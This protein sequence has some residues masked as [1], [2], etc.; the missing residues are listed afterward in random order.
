MKKIYKALLILF[1]FIPFLSVS[2][3]EKVRCGLV[4]NIPSKIP[5]LT[6][7]AF[8][9]IQ[10]IVPILLVLMGSIDLFKGITAQKDEDIKKGQRLFIKRLVVAA[11][12]FFV[13]VVVKFFV[14]I[15]AD[16]SS[17]DAIECID[18]FMNGVEGCKK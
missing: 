5:E 9:I 14:S 3:V 16:A 10:I 15:V 4:T 11:I 1:M 13:V 2:A 17:A 8:D 7:M 6:S 18:C 12:I